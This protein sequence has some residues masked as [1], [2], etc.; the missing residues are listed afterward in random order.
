MSTQDDNTQ[1]WIDAWR[2]AAPELERIRR[3]EIRMADTAA[4]I[5]SMDGLL[6]LISLERESI[7]TSGL[8]EQQ[9]IFHLKP[10]HDRTA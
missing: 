10:P 3:E 9:R 6:S 8:V 4:A 5:R 1:R 7:R 2:R